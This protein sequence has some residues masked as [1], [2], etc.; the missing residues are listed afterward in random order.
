[1]S[2]QFKAF[3]ID[4]LIVALFILPLFIWLN[5]YGTNN[6]EP[7]KLHTRTYYEIKLLFSI[8]I[9]YSFYYVFLLYLIVKD[10]FNISIGKRKYNLKI[11]DRKTGKEA[12]WLKKILRNF[13]FLFPLLILLEFVFKII[14]PRSR[15]GDM[16]LDT[17]IKEKSALKK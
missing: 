9:F 15:F 11:I 17:E 7:L 4:L 8:G 13:T 2:K 1:M 5:F 6:I 16:L 10:V 3:L 14:T 12:H